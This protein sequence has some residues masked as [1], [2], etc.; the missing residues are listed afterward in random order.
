MSFVNVVVGNNGPAC[1]TDNG[2]TALL[3]IVGEGLL[4]RRFQR[5]SMAV[6]PGQ[7]RNCHQATC[8]SNLSDLVYSVLR[9][10]SVEDTA[11]SCSATFTT[12]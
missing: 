5:G 11:F 9:K 4:D 7:V 10:S 3:M 12:S 8:Q 6:P 1:P 2:K